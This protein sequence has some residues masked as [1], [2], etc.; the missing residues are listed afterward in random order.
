MRQSPRHQD[1][2]R[3]YGYQWWL[4]TFQGRTY[5]LPAFAT[6]G[7]GDQFTVVVPNLKLVAAFTGW[8]QG[9]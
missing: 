8:N 3:S 5:L 7:L 9:A 4:H 1:P 2:F 6:Q